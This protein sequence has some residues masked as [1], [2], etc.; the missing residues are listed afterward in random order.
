MTSYEPIPFLN[1][2]GLVPVAS[3]PGELAEYPQSY[4]QADP[5]IVWVIVHSLEATPSTVVL[6]DADDEQLEADVKA[7]DSTITVTFSAPQSGRAEFS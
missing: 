1:V 7:N 6:Y 5:A 4:I 3:D 2:Q